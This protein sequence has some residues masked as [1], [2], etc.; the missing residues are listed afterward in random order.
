MAT[1]I[2]LNIRKSSLRLT[3][4]LLTVRLIQ[5]DSHRVTIGNLDGLK[6]SLETA[7]SD[8]I[9]E[10]NGLLQDVPTTDLTVMS[11]HPAIAKN[12]GA[13]RDY[14]GKRHVV[15][16]AGTIEKRNVTYIASGGKLYEQNKL[17]LASEDGDLDCQPGDE[18]MIF[19]GDRECVSWAV[20]NCHEYTHIDIL[21]ALQ[22]YEIELLVVVTYNAA[23]RLY[24]EYARADVHRLFCFVVIVNVGELG[25][26]GVFA[27][28][29][30]IGKEKNATLSTAGQ[31]FGARG[32]AEVDASMKLEIGCLRQLR[33]TYRTKGFPEK[34]ARDGRDVI[35]PSQRFL[36]TFDVSPG[37]PQ[38]RP[39]Q[40]DNFS[41]NS[42]N[43]VIA[44]CQLDSL[45][46]ET[47]RKTGYR[48]DKAD[49]EVAFFKQR[50]TAKLHELM[51]RCRLREKPAN[52]DFLV[53]PE[54][55]VPRSF[56]PELIAFS[57]ANKTI[58]IA[59]LDYPDDENANECVIIH[60]DRPEGVT[61]FY[62]K[63]T[64]SQYDAQG[65][66]DPEDRQP[67][68][69]GSELLRFTNDSG[70]SFG[71][72]ICYDYSH[73]EL[74][75]RL[76]LGD[77]AEPLDILFVVSH[78]PFGDLYRSCCIADSH[79]FYQHIVM[80]NVAEFGGSGI[81]AP[82]REPGSRQVLCEVGKGIEAT[83]LHQLDLDMQ[84]AMRATADNKLQHGKFMRK[85]GIFQERFTF[86]K[87]LKED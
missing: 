74:I 86:E 46:I 69:R 85:P 55:F 14:A 84:R 73:L 24:W 10:F 29:R 83:G 5:N 52:L 40:I 47:Y 67:L 22:D 44:F 70:A 2:K 43:P 36:H 72:L 6:R 31:M 78:N 68:K 51:L 15:A 59:G 25:G 80:C 34:A 53:M 64:R 62:R 21:R 27:P 11:Y 65:S 45:S 63:I 75:E 32:S 35:L 50:L 60:P 49:N 61:T 87:V 41:W 26:S 56:L 19:K 48:L 18:L 42:K 8:E 81:F 16:L 28:F 58:V 71:V 38:A 82:R 4:E 7:T 13:V 23:S 30:R 37:V 79:R 17:S 12:P 54:V 77:G 76:N 3:D 9:Q 20:L 39:R 66:A 1:N 33:E 57:K